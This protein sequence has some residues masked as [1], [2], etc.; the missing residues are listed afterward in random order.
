MSEKNTMNEL[1][2]GLKVKSTRPVKLHANKNGREWKG[3]KRKQS[4]V[5]LLLI[6]SQDPENRNVR[7]LW[8]MH[9]PLLRTHTHNG[10]ATIGFSSYLFFVRVR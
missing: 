6:D 8:E 7:Q 10:I 1:I 4:C 9:L 5:V 3:E 2:F